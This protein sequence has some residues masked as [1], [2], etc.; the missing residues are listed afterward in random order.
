MKS[1]GSSNEL[2]IKA[3]PEEDLQKLVQVLMYDER[4][5]LDT[6]TGYYRACNA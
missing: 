1:I 6:A 2:D 5:E 3:L 4:I